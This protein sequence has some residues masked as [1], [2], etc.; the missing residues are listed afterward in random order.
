MG[1]ANQQTRRE[2]SRILK[3]NKA[4]RG[5][6]APLPSLFRLPSLSTLRRIGAVP[7][8]RF[9]LLESGDRLSYRY[10][11]QR[12]PAEERSQKADERQLAGCFRQY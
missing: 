3:R 4:G 5:G 11:R 10:G 9:D 2:S 1:L 12:E 7:K 8:T 6:L